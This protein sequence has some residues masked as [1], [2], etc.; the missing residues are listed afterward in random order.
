MIKFLQSRYNVSVNDVNIDTNQ[1]IKKGGV[2]PFFFAYDIS[3]Y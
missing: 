3:M 2:P 1:E